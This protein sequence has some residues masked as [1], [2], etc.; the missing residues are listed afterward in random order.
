MNKGLSKV[1]DITRSLK[2]SPTMSVGD[3]GFTNSATASGPVSGYDAVLPLPDL[4]QDYQTPGESGLAKYRFSNVYPVEK[5]TEKNID[6]MVD[7]SNEYLQLA[8]KSNQRNAE[9][10]INRIRQMFKSL[11]EEAG[12]TMSV[13]DGGYTGK[14]NA[15]GP[16]A[17]YDPVI[18][19]VDRRNKKQKNYPKKYV[20][21][22]RDMM[23]G[24]RL[25]S[26]MT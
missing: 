13:G 12:P 23:K 1:I 21:M 8:D 19:R 16:V 24:Q 5:V 9:E 3:G 10:R 15:S 11:R 7:A 4:S 17:G 20:Q 26:V 6:N 2:E 18:G 14:A 22:Y 25:K